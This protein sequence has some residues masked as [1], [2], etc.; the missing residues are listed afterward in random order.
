MANTKNKGKGG[1]KTKRGVEPTPASKATELDP[2][3]KGSNPLSDFSPPTPSNVF[4]VTCQSGDIENDIFY[5]DTFLG[6]PLNFNDGVCVIAEEEISKYGG[7]EV[8]RRAIGESFI[9]FSVEKKS[10]DQYLADN[11]SSQR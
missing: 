5:I 3:D 10:W 4:C 1:G 9:D 11:V 7:E 6:K 2:Q 8:F